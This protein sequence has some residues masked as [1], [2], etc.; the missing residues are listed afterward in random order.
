MQ[1]EGCWLKYKLNLRNIKLEDVAK[2]AHRTVATVS[3]VIS[4]KRRSESV[5]AVLAAMLGYPSW[6]HLWDD[7]LINAERRAV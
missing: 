1:P 2:K 6:K 5:E 7:A 3:R 4:G